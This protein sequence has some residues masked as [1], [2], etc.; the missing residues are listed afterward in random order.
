MKRTLGIFLLFAVII[1]LVYSAIQIYSNE[2]I[3]ETLNNDVLSKSAN[4]AIDLEMTEAG[5]FQISAEVMV[6]NDSQESWSDI[7]FFFVANEMNGESNVAEVNSIS[8][9]GNQIDYEL[10]NGV[11]FIEL[12][13]DLL[14]GKQQTVL[15]EY[16]LDVPEDGLRLTRSENNVYLAHWYPMLAEYDAGW[17]V[18]E[19]DP[20]GESYETGY[21]DYAITY[22]LP[23]EYLIATSAPDGPAQASSSGTLTGAAIKDF[24]A[25][26][27]NPADWQ[28]AERKSGETELRVFVPAESAILEETAELSVEAFAFFEQ[29]IGD[30]PFA[31][32]DLIANDG[33]MEYPN[34]VEVPMDKA[35]LDSILVHE[36]AH[37]WF[38]YLVSNDPY[39]NAWLDESL[40][41]F[42]TGLFL[43]DYYGDEDGG[44]QTA[45]AYKDSTTPKPYADLALDEFDTAA[46]YATIY[47]EVPLLLK[48]FF[49]QQGGN[50]AAFE[51]L[52]AYYEEFQFRRVTKQQFREFFE[53][54]FQGDQQ[55]FLDSWLQS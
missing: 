36:I 44:F 41:E 3:D 28:V 6:S 25:A 50:E 55:E 4:Y 5:A 19:Y 39:E 13:L 22:R 21:G 15:V 38:Y 8:S 30:Y 11:L 1:I 47:G 24:Y 23:D 37:Q 27:L 51:F 2:P 32:L 40:T 42:S 31:E 29:N 49:D 20:K 35:L 17:Q 12:E 9:A 10:I 46:Y 45:Q 7:A 34:I 14:P 33:Y 16:T 52:A 54:Y 26:F 53:G 43:S 48:V 18:N